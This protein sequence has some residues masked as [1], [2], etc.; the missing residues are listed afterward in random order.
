MVVDFAKVSVRD[1]PLLILQNLDDTSIGV[2][3]SAFHVEVDLC[4]NEISTLTFDLPAF[5]NGADTANYQKTVGMRII[6]LKDYGRFLLVDPKITDDGVKQIKSC[7]AYSLEYEFTFKKLPL[8]AGTYNLWNPIASKGTILGLILELM[9]S[10]KVGQVDAS[11]VDRYRTFDDSGDQNIYNF[12]KSDL[13]QSYGC[14]FTFDT[15]KRIIHVRD[16][17]AQAPL[18]PVYFSMENLVKKVTID[19]DTESIIT[20]LNV[21]GADGVDIR[22]VNPMGTSSIIEL[23]YFMTAENFSQSIIDNYNDW[24]TTFTSYQRQYFNLTVEEALKTA[25]LVTEQ[26]ALATLQSERTSLENIQAVTIQGIAQKLKTQSDLDCVNTQIQAKQ[27]EISDKRNE[28]ETIQA[29]VDDINNQMLEINQETSLERFFTAAEY[30][31]ISRYL[32]EDSI[33]EDSFVVPEVDTYDAA[34]ESIKLNG[35]VFNITNSTVIQVQNTDGKNIYS[36]SGGTITCSDA[37]FQLN[38]ALIRAS[39]DNAVNGEFLFTARLSAGT[40]NGESFPSACI[41]IAGTASSVNTNVTADSS[42]QGAISEGTE[43]SFRLGSAN[44]YFTR[45]TT[46]YEQRSVEW[47]LFDYGTE[48][49]QKVAWP[50][51]TFSLDLAN[52][53]ALSEFEP[54]KA[55][56]EL[57]S[58]LYFKQRDGTILK[59]ILVG[60]HIPFEDLSKFSMELSS[61]YNSNSCEFTYA[62]FYDD[63]QSAGATIDSGKWTYN[64]FVNSG[65][66]TSLSKFM[67]SALDIAKNNIMSSVGQAISWDQAGFRLRKRKDGSE[68]EFEPYQIWMNNSSIMFTTDNWATANLAIGQIVSE[69]GNILSGVIADSLIGKLLAGS[70]LIIES[71]K[72]DGGTAV[73]RVDGNGAS[74]HNA[75]FDIYNANQVQIT[76]NPY[77]GIAIGKYPV[78]SGNNYAINTNNATFWV[79][80][81]GNVHIKGTLEGC[82]GKFSGELV[83]ASGRFKGVVQASAYQDLSGRNM[84]TND[85]KFGADYLELKGLNVNNNFIVDS[86]GKVT[87]RGNITMTG[88]SISWANI[89]ERGSAAYQTAVSANSL[90]NSAYG[91]ATAAGDNVAKLANG[92][93]SGTF[94]DGRRLISP[95]IYT[96][97]LTVSVPDGYN[98]IAGLLMKGH[99]YGREYNVLQ[100]SNYQEYIHMT[101]PCGA[102]VDWDF[103]RTEFKGNL[104]FSQARSIVGLDATFG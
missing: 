94:I 84:L 44:L 6:N 17:V 2:L 14:I 3:K 20:K 75:V 102:Y 28:L 69:N 21:Y 76:L 48:L 16:I 60:V 87:I 82:D 100:I 45:S 80:T 42:V 46:E 67:K 78:Y 91:K 85:Y 1:Q 32:K 30:K 54:F 101:S 65:A 71:A 29:Q 72:K 52:F 57:G 40:L 103:G 35:A 73:F 26:A 62:D 41:S 58:K 79:D 11:L 23:G 68:T 43:I 24:K 8:T 59:P 49:I 92:S 74:L 86:S 9:P 96:N 33:S 25:Q 77:S 34:G 50:A 95:E 27:R 64:Q 12:M 31:I 63:A 93:Y 81:K 37:K 88:G 53:M 36:A 38:A 10:W 83:A 70:S 18:K 5:A 97:M 7:T 56:L 99:I 51:Y 4:Y 19:E 66:E 89:N 15:Y 98:G 90:A 22:S 47:D 104:D 55:N 61:K 13:Q 39:L